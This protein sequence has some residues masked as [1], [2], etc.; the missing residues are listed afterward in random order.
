MAL[1][2]ARPNDKTI[3]SQR[4]TTICLD[5]VNRA[6]FEKDFLHDF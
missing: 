5:G 1:P 4:K 6:I 3:S 2:R